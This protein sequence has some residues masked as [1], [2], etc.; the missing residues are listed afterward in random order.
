MSQSAPAEEATA[1]EAIVSASKLKD[2]IAPMEPIVQEFRLQLTE[3]GFETLAADPANVAV[4]KS[5]LEAGAFESY[6]PGNGGELGIPLTK[7]GGFADVLDFAEADDLVHLALDPET[8]RLDI[9][10]DTVEMDFALIDTESIRPTPDLPEFDFAVDVTL[11]GA[12][13][14]RS[15]DI[16][17]MVS[18]HIRFV[19]EPEESQW[20][21]RADGDTDSVGD[22][23]GKDDLVEGQVPDEHETL[24]SVDYLADMAKPI[25]KDAEDQVRHDTE[26]PVKWWWERGDVQAMNMLAPRIQSQ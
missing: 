2:F 25:P 21:I 15:I 3:E 4:A 20:A 8:R 10:F 7:D 19:G 18:D 22:T 26:K 1:F 17:E 13:F 14:S 9:E 11:T 23:Y 16:C 24:L 6:E 5:T 12:Q